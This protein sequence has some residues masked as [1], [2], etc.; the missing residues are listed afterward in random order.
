M[1]PEFFGSLSDKQ[2]PLCA[3]LRFHAW[4][5]YGWSPG[6][7]KVERPEGYGDLEWRYLPAIADP[8][9]YVHQRL[10]Q[11]NNQRVHL[12]REVMKL[13]SQQQATFP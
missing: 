12:L 2:G 7:Q 4:D 11:L 1:M 13:G 10:G 5:R 6:N 8:Q 9:G 3:Y